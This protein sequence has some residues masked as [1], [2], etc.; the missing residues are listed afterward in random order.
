MQ[1]ETS[2]VRGRLVWFFIKPVFQ[3]SANWNK[4]FCAEKSVAG[5]TETGKNIS[6][7]IKASVKG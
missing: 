6:V 1:T 7:F 5:V 2:L 4:L 3:I